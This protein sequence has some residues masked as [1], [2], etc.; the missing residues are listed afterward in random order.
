MSDGESV[1]KSH[2]AANREG[3]RVQGP[4]GR[5]RMELPDDGAGSSSIY[6]A[7]SSSIYGAGSS[8]E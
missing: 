3:L 5:I 6:G 7:G 1:S 8:S 2:P 4:S